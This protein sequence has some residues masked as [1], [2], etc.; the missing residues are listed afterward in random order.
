LLAAEVP[1]F[2]GDFCTKSGAEPDTRHRT[3]SENRSSLNAKPN[4]LEGVP[5]LVKETSFVMT[6]VEAPDRNEVSAEEVDGPE[7]VV[8]LVVTATA[9]IGASLCLSN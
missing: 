2:P 8:E 9:D 5:A 7:T 6:E 1:I 4:R 3:R